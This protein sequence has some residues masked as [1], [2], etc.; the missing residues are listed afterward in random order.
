MYVFGTPVSV[1]AVFHSHGFGGCDAFIFDIM[2]R[3]EEVSVGT[4]DLDGYPVLSRRKEFAKI[5]VIAKHQL[6]YRLSVYRNLCRRIRTGKTEFCSASVVP[7]LK[8][9][10]SAEKGISALC[11]IRPI[12]GNVLSGDCKISAEKSVV[13][14]SVLKFAVTFNA[15]CSEKIGNFDFGIKVQAVAK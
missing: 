13:V 12:G 4:P 11:N 2:M 6:L 10:H 1:P 9:K 15:E 7:Y 3:T 5:A 8:F 14:T